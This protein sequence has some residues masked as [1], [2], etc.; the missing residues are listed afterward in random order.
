[1]KVLPDGSM[2]MPDGTIVGANGAPVPLPVPV[3][4]A[5]PGAV[6][7]VAPSGP[8]RDSYWPRSAAAWIVLS[9]VLVLLSVNLVSPTRRWRPRLWRRRRG[10]GT[11]VGAAPTP[12]GEAAISASTAASPE[13]A[14]TGP[15][16]PVGDLPATPET[17]A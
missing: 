8:I 1:V 9:I 14:L 11:A 15:E 3:D 7:A 13:G 4:Q 17:G 16:G 10:A 5:Q 6:I 2:V 12:Q